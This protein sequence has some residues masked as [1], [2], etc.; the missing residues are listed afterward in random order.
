M[1]E[2]DAWAQEYRPEKIPD[3][4]SSDPKRRAGDALYDFTED[5][6]LVREGG[7]HTIDHREHDL[8]GEYALLS[9]HFF[10]FGNQPVALPEHL[11]GIVKLGPGHRS[12]ENAPYLEPFVEWLAG[13]ALQPNHLYGKPQKMLLPPVTGLALTRRSKHRMR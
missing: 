6:P 10:Y 3:R 1:R 2:Y 5:P 9:E 13:L 7:A 8:S 4:R 12:R 11:L